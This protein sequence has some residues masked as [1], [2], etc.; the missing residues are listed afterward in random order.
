VRHRRGSGGP[1]LAVAVV[2]LAGL[3]AACS[4]AASQTPGPL[5]TSTLLPPSSATS[6]PS[7]GDVIPASPVV[8]V[9]TDVDSEGLDKVTGFTLRT[10]EGRSLEFT[11]GELENPTEFPP[12]HLSEHLATGSPVRVFFELQ[13]TSLVAYRLADGD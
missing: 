12:G 1:R 13:G 3:A 4:P 2:L 7:A 10:N 5:P 6:G 8:G 11:I 9:L